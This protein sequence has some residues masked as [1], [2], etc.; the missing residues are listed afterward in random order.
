M[1]R[2]HATDLD[3]GGSASHPN[4][5]AGLGDAEAVTLGDDATRLQLHAVLDAGVFDRADHPDDEFVFGLER[6]LVP[7]PRP[8]PLP[9][10]PGLPQTG[11]M[12][13]STK[14]L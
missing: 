10:Q 1:S 4:G 6:I 12:T 7:L 8:R 3:E 5:G 11:E 14:A 2:K 9:T 13:D